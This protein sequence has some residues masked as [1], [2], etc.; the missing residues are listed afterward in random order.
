MA[1]VGIHHLGLTVTDIEASASWYEAV[2]GFERS[3][4]YAAAGGERAKVFLRHDHLQVRIGLTEH[5]TAAHSV[6]DETRIGL[7]HLAYQVDTEAELREWERHL[8]HHE[9]PFT[10]VAPANSIPGA[11]VLV[12]RDPDNIQLELFYDPTKAAGSSSAA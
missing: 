12:F 8:A 3:G 5:T 10:P 9:V 1:I 4:R 6:F 7:D 11:L 2:L